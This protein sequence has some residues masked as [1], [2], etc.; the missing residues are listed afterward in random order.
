VEALRVIAAAYLSDELGRTVEPD[1]RDRDS[2][3]TLALAQ[4]VSA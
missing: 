1:G 3:D 2:V 4:P